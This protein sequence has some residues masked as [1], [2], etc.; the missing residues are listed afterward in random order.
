MH[1]G[2]FNLVKVEVDGPAIINR[3]MKTGSVE[4]LLRERPDTPEWYVSC[5]T[6]G[7]STVV[8]FAWDHENRRWRKV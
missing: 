4:E 2:K 7:G 6:P 3:L 8:V 5:L 1:Q